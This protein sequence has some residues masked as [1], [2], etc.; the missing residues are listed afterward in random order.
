MSLLASIALGTGCVR[1]ECALPDYSTSECRVQAEALLAL[2]T[3]ASGVELRFQDPGSTQ[4]ASWSALGLVDTGPDGRLIARVAT[5]GGFRLSLHRNT[6]QASR[7]TV[8]LTNVHPLI[9]PLEGQIEQHG[10]TRVLDLE[11]RDEVIEIRGRLPRVACDGG[12]ELAAVGDIQTGPLTF[13]G[14]VDDLHR[15]AAQA[16]EIG[17]PLLGL[18]LLGD[19]AEHGSEPEL[20]RIAQILR[21]SPVPVAVTPGNHDIYDSSLPLFNQRFG[22]G[23]YA[24]DVC[25]AHVVM[26]DTGNADLAPSIQGWLPT[27]LD[28]DQRF[29]IA[30]THIPP[31]AADTANGWRREDQAQHLLAELSARGTDALLAGHIHFRLELHASPVREVIVGTGGASQGQIDPDYGYLRATFRDR[32]E[33][34]YLPLPAPGSPGPSPGREPTTCTERL[35][36][37]PLGAGGSKPAA[38]TPRCTRRRPAEPADAPLWPR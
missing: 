29:L 38:P 19:L 25:D 11:L 31:Y 26:L 35:P 32:L 30:G 17:V 9:E 24:F 36:P 23:S 2:N 18:L 12:F 34:C 1:P 13:E 20:D 6:S 33:L 14:I 7:V 28:H 10:L 27:L 16:D 37:P 3:D 8:E 15:E 21:R 22:P 5:L 4:T